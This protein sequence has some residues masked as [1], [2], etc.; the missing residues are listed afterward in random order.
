LKTR[1]EAPH[2]GRPAGVEADIVME[3][4]FMQGLDGVKEG[5]RLFVLCWFHVSD[6][7]TLR[8]HPRRD[9]AIAKRGVFATRSPDR[10]NP[11]GLCLVDVLTIEG[12]VIKVRGLDALDG[13]PVVDIKPY[14]KALDG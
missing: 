13:T 1:D 2:Q 5:D 14:S 3:E 8:V 11:I 12:S 4:R 10:P 9:T 6:R 7:D